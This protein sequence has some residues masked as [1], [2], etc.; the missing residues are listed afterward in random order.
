[1]SKKSLNIKFLPALILF[2]VFLIL[3]ASRADA[4]VKIVS[5]YIDMLGNSIYNVGNLNSTGWINGTNINGTYYGDGANLLSINT[6]NSTYD[7]LIGSGG[8]GANISTTTCSGTDKVSAIDNAT[9]IVTCT[10]DSGG[11]TT[12]VVV[13]QPVVVRQLAQLST[14]NNT[15]WT[16]TDLQFSVEADNKYTMLC[17]ILFRGD[18]ATTGMA[19]NVSANFTSSNVNIMYDTWSSATANVGF[20]ATAF[21]TAL[22]GTGSGATIIKP[23]LVVVDFDTTSSGVIKIQIRSEISASNTI[24]ERGSK[25]ELYNRTAYTSTPISNATGKY[26]ATSYQDADLSTTSNTVWSTTQFNFT[27]DTDKTYNLICDILF[28]GAAATTGQAINISSSATTSNVNIMYDTWSSATAPVG[29]SAT[30][31]ET[32]L[33]GTGSG[34]AVVRP[35]LVIAD[36]T[37]TSSGT[38]IFQI[39]SEVSASAST[40][41]KGSTCRLYDMT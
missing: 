36:F 23:N 37:T 7:A 22:V 16:D 29:F 32:A 31:F 27:L 8:S 24:I 10:A 30:A 18:V 40:I 1:M 41:K 21:E 33:I 39:R 38:L 20:S 14:N 3:V 2:F 9:G 28:T 17:N 35:N 15:V 34:T 11:G 25:C 6:Y 12:T 19:I 4:L 5:T 13:G 26:P